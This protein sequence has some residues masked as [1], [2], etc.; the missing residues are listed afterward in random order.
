MGGCRTEKGKCVCETLPP[1]GRKCDLREFLGRLACKLGS[2]ILTSKSSIKSNFTA[3]SQICDAISYNEIAIMPT[4]YSIFMIAFR[5]PLRESVHLEMSN[6]ANLKALVA[7]VALHLS[8]CFDLN[9]LI[10][11]TENTLLYHAALRPA[12]F[13]IWIYNTYRDPVVEGLVS[14]P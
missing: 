14:S 11:Y 9:H 10:R 6:K 5:I 4:D 8:H 2:F 1:F 12:T 13:D 3:L 7:L